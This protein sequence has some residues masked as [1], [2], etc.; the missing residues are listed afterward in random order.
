[1]EGVPETAKPHNILT[2]DPDV[3]LGTVFL[4]IKEY[5]GSEEEILNHLLGT[6]YPGFKKGRSNHWAGSL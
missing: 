5:A 6:Q 3:P 2:K 1:M 4:Q